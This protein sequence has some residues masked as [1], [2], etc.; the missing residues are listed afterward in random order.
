MNGIDRI[1]DRMERDARAERDAIRAEGGEPPVQF[2]AVTAL[3]LLWFAREKCDIVVLE[4]GL[5]GKYDATNAVTRK[6]VAAITKIGKD[7][8]ELLGDTLAEIS[9][10]KAGEALPGFRRPCFTDCASF[11]GSPDRRCQI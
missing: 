2:E 9:A 1:R 10:Q 5:G 11:H 8:T 4:T 6:L 7:H 3:A